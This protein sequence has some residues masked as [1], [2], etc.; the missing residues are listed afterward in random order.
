MPTQIHPTAVVEK[1][2]ELGADVIIGPLAY[3]GA[4]VRLG[5]GCVLHHHASVEGD[6]RLG[7][8][9][10][11]FP[12]ACIGGKTQDLKFT[13][14][15]CGVRI[16]ARNVFRE[17][18]TVHAAT[19][20]GTYTSL[21]DDNVL[22]ATCHIAHDCVLGNHI[23]MSNGAGFAGHVVCEDHVTCG[24]H[25]GV[26]QFCRV[27]SY[28]MLGGYAK[29]VQDVPPYMIADG[30][31]AV[32]RAINKIGLE[33]KGFHADQVERVKFIYK[34]LFREGLNRTQALERLRAH[35]QAGTAEIQ[36]LLEF[37]EKS[38]RGLVPGA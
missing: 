11:V 24:A 25:S 16:G 14:G 28:A 37:A 18:V 36:H 15:R 20:D 5:D 4:Q 3:V 33:R 9:C 7:P 38:E 26:H 12:F 30:Q 31:P 6:T 19:A 10:E 34:T 32:I 1:G 13:G 27:G 21:G 8:G 17:Y 35:A 29:V 23:V 22:L 2:A